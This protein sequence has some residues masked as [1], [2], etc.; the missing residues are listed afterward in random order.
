MFLEL[1]NHS[2]NDRALTQQQSVKDGQELLSHG[3]LDLD[4]E[5]QAVLAQQSGECARDVTF[6]ADEL[7]Q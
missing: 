1:G 5:L 6:V 7:A 2:F 4:D 3:A